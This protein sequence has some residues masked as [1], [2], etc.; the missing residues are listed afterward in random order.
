MG[1][2]YRALPVLGAVLLAG[3]LVVA[4]LG[5]WFPREPQMYRDFFIAHRRDCWL[6]P[7]AEAVALQALAQPEIDPP[8]LDRNAA[9]YILVRGWNPMP[10]WGET[11]QAKT[12]LLDLP[13]LAGAKTLEVTLA[14]A[15]PLRPQPVRVSLD[16]K[17]AA[18]LVLPPGDVPVMLRV[19]VPAPAK[20]GNDVQIRFLRSRPVDESPMAV[21]RLQW[22]H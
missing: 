5:I 19:P 10:P 4:V 12:A 17:F 21:L 2:L 1:S 11:S 9:C 3:E 6:P 13:S 18:S 20:P 22:I 14:N 16:G 8:R 15:S 7:V